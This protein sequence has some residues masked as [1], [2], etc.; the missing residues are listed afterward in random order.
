MLSL[1]KRLREDHNID[2]P[3]SSD[4][5]LMELSGVCAV[6]NIPFLVVVQ[7]HLLKDKDCVRLRRYPFDVINQSS[8]STS[9]VVVPLDDLASTILGDSSLLEEDTEEQAEGA[10]NQNS[11]FRE[12]RPSRETQVECILVVEDAY[13]G[14][15]REVSKNETP[16]WKTY[17]KAMKSISLS[18]ESYLYSL[19]DS[20]SQAAAGMQGLPVFA[21]ADISFWALRD[22]G[23]AL[24]RREGSEKSAFG[25]SNEIIG[26]SSFALL[27]TTYRTLRIDSRIPI[28]SSTGAD[29]YPKHKR[30]LKTLAVAMDNFMKRHGIWGQGSQQGHRQR[31]DHKGSSSLMTVLLYSKSDVRFDMVTLSC[32][33]SGGSGGS[34]TTRRK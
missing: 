27:P 10:T 26:I 31:H 6:L 9:E 33:A 3:G 34:S 15:D 32:D 22:F 2:T 23:T 29:K 5:S 11:S 16:Q 12:H 28:L 14:N 18:A 8:G 4:W 25:A 20:K 13:F 30:V 21:I 7:P 17:R 1:L 19:Q 24:M